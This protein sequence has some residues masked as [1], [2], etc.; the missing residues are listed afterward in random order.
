MTLQE[1]GA[2]GAIVTSPVQVQPAHEAD[3]AAWDAFVDAHPESRF[4]QLWGYRRALEHAYGYPCVYLDVLADGERV[5]MFPSVAIRQGSGRLV[6]QPM[7]EYGGPLL[8]PLSPENAERAAAGLLEAGRRAGCATVEIRGGFGA[9][10]LATSERCVVHPMH[11]VAILTLEPPDVLWKKHVRHEARKGVN[12]AQRAGLRT[13]VRRG[14]AAVADPFYDLYLVS[15]KRLGVPPHPRRFFEEL[16]SG[17][18]ERVVA[19]WT[20]KDDRTAAVLLGFTVGRRVQIFVI[21]SATEFWE[22]R[23]N[24][25]THWALITWAWEQSFALFDFGSA[26]YPGQIHYKKKWGVEFVDYRYLMLAAAGSEA[27]KKI[28]TLKTSSPLMDRMATA[29]RSLVPLRLTP[30]L[31]RPIRRFLTK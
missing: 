23:P 20:L 1:S 28:Q 22:L 29:W 5:G 13:E 9:E 16:V 25:L 14:A 3:A 2:T 4:C 15:M 31:G 21:A 8:R 12:S 6:S 17:L 27:A 30:V 18:G 24:D 7:N 10:S 11:H 19:S 26:R